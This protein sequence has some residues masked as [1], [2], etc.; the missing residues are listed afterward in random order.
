[1]TIFRFLVGALFLALELPLLV[2]A[3]ISAQRREDHWL[4][5]LL[6]CPLCKGKQVLA[7]YK[8][9]R[10][11]GGGMGKCLSGCMTNNPLVL[12]MMLKMMPKVDD[13]STVTAAPSSSNDAAEIQEEAEAANRLNEAAHQEGARGGSV[14]SEGGVVLL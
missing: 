12:D 2:Q 8:P 6:G 13:S 3:E 1:M 9:C 10:E 11:A 14:D 4:K 7:C 5:S